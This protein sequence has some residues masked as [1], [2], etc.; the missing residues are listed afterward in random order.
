M[1]L[2][3]HSRRSKLGLLTASILILLLVAWHFD[4]TT[5]RRNQSAGPAPP[6]PP[7]NDVVILYAY[8]ETE[9]A[10]PNAE[11]FIRHALHDAA[12]FVFIL[13]G[14]SDLDKFIPKDA[15]NVRV[16]R[17]KNE[18]Y[19]IGAYGEVLHANDNEIA[20]RYK[21]FILMNSSIRGPFVPHWS[22]DCWSDAYLR[23]IDDETKLVG[24]TYNCHPSRHIQS[25]ILATDTTGLWLLL[26]PSN[27][28]LSG[29]HNEHEAAIG[30]EVRLTALIKESGYKVDV[31]MEEFHSDKDFA[32]SCQQGDPLW[33]GQYEGI[34][35]HPYETL[36]FKTNRQITQDVLDRYTE[37]TDKSEYSSYKVCSKPSA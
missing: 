14:E 34:T 13:N 4:P 11:F 30:A 32:N 23:K 20:G 15:T 21:K 9:F 37:W 22:N 28:A 19:D 2:E 33:E 10:R 35:I 3:A 31:M 36:F 18:C 12:D 26:E 27:N 1:V 6:T 5:L 7:Q 25:M 29:C 17:R 24:M 16:V 8:H